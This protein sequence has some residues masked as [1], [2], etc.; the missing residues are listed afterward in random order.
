M[1][2]RDPAQR[3]AVADCVPMSPVRIGLVG[4]AQ[5][6]LDLPFTPLSYAGVARRTAFRTTAVVASTTAAT[7]TAAEQSA[8]VAAAAAAPPPPA[9]GPVPVGTV[10]TRLPSGFVSAS[11]SGVEYYRCD[12]NYYRATR[13]EAVSRAVPKVP[14]HAHEARSA[15]ID[16][17]RRSPR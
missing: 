7:T 12:G 13:A 3:P 15:S 6:I 9:A 14:A 5:A 8:A 10:V 16:H 17:P 2:L 4:Q 1:R 11:V